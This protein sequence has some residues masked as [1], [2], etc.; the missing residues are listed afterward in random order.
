MSWTQCPPPE[1][2]SRTF[3]R[4]A[5]PAIESSLPRAPAGAVSSS[6]TRPISIVEQEVPVTSHHH[7]LDAP[8]PPLAQAAAHA[9]RTL[10]PYGRPAKPKMHWQEPGRDQTKRRSQ[11]PVLPGFA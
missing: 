11:A 8:N 9:A 6:A 7:S 2:T 5:A 3:R 4:G 10:E 1:A